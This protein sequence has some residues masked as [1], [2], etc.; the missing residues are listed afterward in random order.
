MPWGQDFGDNVAEVVI[1]DVDSLPIGDRGAVRS[2]REC[3]GEVGRAF[4][5]PPWGLYDVCYVPC[6]LS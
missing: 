6:Q 2:A 5:L 3:A 1:G 4:G